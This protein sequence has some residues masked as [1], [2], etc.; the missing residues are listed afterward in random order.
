VKTNEMRVNTPWHLPVKSFVAR[1][2]HATVRIG[3]Q[4]ICIGGIQNT[5]HS[6]NEIV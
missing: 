1:R 2:R 6:I 5:G 4:V 3:S